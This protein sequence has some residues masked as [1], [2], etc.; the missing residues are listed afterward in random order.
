MWG[1]DKGYGS[2]CGIIVQEVERDSMESV[3]SCGWVRWGEVRWRRGRTH[4]GHQEACGVK[5]RT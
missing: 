3:V 4:L 1:I 5:S 2:G